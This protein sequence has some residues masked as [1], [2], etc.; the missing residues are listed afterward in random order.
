[1][2]CFCV[3]EHTMDNDGKVVH[4]WECVSLGN[5]QCSL[6]ARPSARA[7]ARA[8]TRA[9]PFVLPFVRPFGPS[10]FLDLD[11]AGIICAY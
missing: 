7:P 11:L 9:R 3:G 1:M 2:G 6:R 4:L 8:S 10:S 5:T